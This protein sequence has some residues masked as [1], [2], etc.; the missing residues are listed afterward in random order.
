MTTTRLTQAGRIALAPAALVVVVGAVAGLAHHQPPRA[1]AA[2]HPAGYTVATGNPAPAPALIPRAVRQGAAPGRAPGSAVPPRT[3]AAALDDRAGITVPYWAVAAVLAVFLLAAAGLAVLVHR[4]ALRQLT[5]LREALRALEGSRRSADAELAESRYR[6]EQLRGAGS[7]LQQFAYV[8]SHDLREPLRKVI[9]FCQLLEKRYGD[10]LDERGLQYIAYAVDGAK[11]MQVLL[12]DL[13]AFARSG[14]PDDGD[15]EVALDES[16]DQALANLAG[17]IE[18]CGAGVERPPVLPR[19]IGD[20]TLL[21]MLWQNL[22][23]NAVAFRSQDRAPRIAIT[24]D[25]PDEDGL[26]GFAVTDNG[27]GVPAAY[28]EKVFGVVPRPREG[29]PRGDG[30]GIGLAL[31]KKIVEHHGGRIWLDPAPREGT[32]IRFTLPAAARPAPLEE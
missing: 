6:E 18:E 29:E 2:G 16:L 22:L 11:R 1:A 23:G 9:S 32:R 25:G 31:C 5:P 20:P 28:A 10:R 14:R 13:L 17:P 21:T 8:A 12:G 19:T 30:N 24:S 3:T 7:E 15:V 4:R 27:V 26:L